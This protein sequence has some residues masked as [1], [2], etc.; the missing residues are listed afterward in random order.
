[1]QLSGQQRKAIAFLSQVEGAAITHLLTDDANFQVNSQAFGGFACALIEGQGVVELMFSKTSEDLLRDFC[2]LIYTISG[3]V[4]GGGRDDVI[5][6]RVGELILFRSPE[7]FRIRFSS[8]FKYLIC[9]VSRDRLRKHG[10]D[11]ECVEN[12]PIS[13]HKSAGAVL[14]GALNGVAEAILDW[15]EGEQLDA[16]AP[17]L[18]ALIGA[19]FRPE[20]L[21]TER[22][23]REGSRFELLKQAIKANVADPDI[24]LAD[25]ARAGGVSPRTVQRTFA[26][27]GTTFK[28][29]LMSERLQKAAFFLSR[30]EYRQISIG[31]ISARCGFQ[32]QSYFCVLFRE[33]FG[34]SPQSFRSANANRGFL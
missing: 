34:I 5:V 21:M 32:A 27:K 12:V 16:V 9:F 26:E 1:M 6:A 23:S 3:V 22:E 28:A 13:A 18:V 20:H 14:A 11:L 24:R 33:R 15:S 4:T 29:M 25:L 19:V 7:Q 8:D 2:T 10:V 30:R 31:E 17:S